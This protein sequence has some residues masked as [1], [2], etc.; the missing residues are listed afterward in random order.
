MELINEINQIKKIMGLTHLNEAA[1]G[2]LDDLFKA[3]KALLTNTITTKPAFKSFINNGLSTAP[4]LE[5]EIISDP[6]LGKSLKLQLTIAKNSL[7]M[8]DPNRFLINARI[9]EIDAILPKTTKKPV[10]PKPKVDNEIILDIPEISNSVKT[11][12]QKL[13]INADEMFNE[14]NDSLPKEISRA[15][16]IKLDYIEKMNNLNIEKGEES[17]KYSKELNGL[18]LLEKEVKVK[19]SILEKDL[20]TLKNKEK[21]GKITDEEKLRK[22]EI[23]QKMTD[24]RTKQFKIIGKIIGYTSLGI[25]AIMGLNYFRKWVCEKTESWG[26]CQYFKLKGGSNNGGG[27]TQ[28]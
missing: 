11:T 12:A 4:L 7:E 22:I 2:W 1:G 15:E 16:K 24:L 8:T 21:H 9:K 3:T 25:I 26:F 28:I 18:N 13:G 19:T 17:L 14:I 10:T 6:A 23:Q 5:K 27:G 20:V